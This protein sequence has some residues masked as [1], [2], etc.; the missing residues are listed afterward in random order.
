[1]H[2]IAERQASRQAAGS[3]LSAPRTRLSTWFLLPLRYSLAPSN[4]QLCGEACDGRDPSTPSTSFHYP[5]NT[6]PLPIA[7]I[8]SVGMPV[9]PSPVSITPSKYPLAP[10]NPAGRPGVLEAWGCSGVRPRGRHHHHG[11]R[12]AYSGVSIILRSTII[13]HRQ[14]SPC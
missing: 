12:D 14:G 4:H 10:I 1:M 9:I 5:F 2:L 11:L 6:R 13:P 7:P 8:N 3:R